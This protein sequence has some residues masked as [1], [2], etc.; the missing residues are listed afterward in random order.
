MNINRFSIDAVN[1]DDYPVLSDVWES[2][3]KATHHFLAL[4]DFQF[5][6]KLVPEFLTQ[7][8]L[9]C[10]KNES[11]RIIGF[12]GTNNEALEMLFIAAEERGHG[13]GRQL[14][15]YAFEHSGI[16]KVDVNEQ[17]TAAVSF[18]NYFGF[19]TVGRSESD[20]FGKPYPVLHME[21]SK[22]GRSVAF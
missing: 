5:Y 13:A 8:S 2:S 18:Y 7:V 9:K 17:N 10:L 20:G 1:A 14:L 15:H 16:T 4:D 21:L 11:G 6:K 3:V 12:M 19:E 22:R